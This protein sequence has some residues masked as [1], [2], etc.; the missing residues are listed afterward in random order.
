MQ[1]KTTLQNGPK[2][3]AWLIGSIRRFWQKLTHMVKR[4]FTARKEIAEEITT[5]AQENPRLC[6]GIILA[7]VLALLVRLIPLIGPLLSPV[8]L[9]AGL[10]IGMIAGFRADQN[11][12]GL[13]GGSIVEYGEDL[14]AA[15]SKIGTL[16]AAITVLFWRELQEVV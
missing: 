11:K 10:I 7:I 4:L 2:K 9:I 8:V 16:L 15:A 5:F 14:V 3:E 1:Q 12:P 13:S 6:S